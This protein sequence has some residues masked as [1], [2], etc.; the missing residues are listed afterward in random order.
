MKAAFGILNFIYTRI[1]DNTNKIWFNQLLQIS[2]KELGSKLIKEIPKAD[3]TATLEILSEIYGEVIPK[4]FIPSLKLMLSAKPASYENILAYVLFSYYLFT[5]L[6]EIDIKLT[7]WNNK[8]EDILN[9]SKSLAISPNHIGERANW[10]LNFNRM[11]ELYQHKWYQIQKEIKNKTMDIFAKKWE[12]LIARKNR[13]ISTLNVLLDNY[14]DMKPIVINFNKFK[15][16]ISAIKNWIKFGKYAYNGYKNGYKNK[17]ARNFDS[18][19]LYI[20]SRLINK[21][22]KI[23][24]RVNITQEHLKNVLE[25]LQNEENDIQLCKLQHTV[26]SLQKDDKNL[27]DKLTN[28]GS[29]QIQ[30]DNYEKVWKQM[31]LSKIEKL[32]LTLNLQYNYIINKLENYGG[33][34]QLSKILDDVDESAES[35]EFSIASNISSSKRK[36]PN[37]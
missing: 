20:G 27:I 33:S 14:K 36:Q 23:I 29:Y 22:C 10:L 26:E 30:L 6:A 24:K 11:D 8:L 21:L 9:L 19:T 28:N 35:T 17:Y 2:T 31:N 18:K 12:T 15:H 32:G 37:T 34:G 7:A 4:K 16:D 1:S 25:N 5:K 13:Q 3:K